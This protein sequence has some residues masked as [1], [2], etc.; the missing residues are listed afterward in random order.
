MGTGLADHDQLIAECQRNERRVRDLVNEPRIKEILVRLPDW[1]QL[2]SS[3]DALGSQNCE[4]PS[5]LRYAVNPQK[6][7]RRLP[8]SL[9][10]SLDIKLS[11][12]RN[13]ASEIDADYSK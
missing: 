3:L 4:P 7:T 8:V 13:M 1:Y 12:L 10:I 9:L 2:C 11:D 5:I 6:P